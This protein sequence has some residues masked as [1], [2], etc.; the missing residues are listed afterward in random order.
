MTTKVILDE[1]INLDSFKSLLGKYQD[2]KSCYRELKINSITG[3]K[4][5]FEISELNPP[6]ICGFEKKENYSYNVFHVSQSCFTINS[7]DMVV[8][9]KLQVIDIHLKIKILDTESG[10]LLSEVLEDVEFR[11]WNTYKDGEVYEV[12]GF[13][14]ISSLKLSA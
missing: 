2:F 3:K 10:K 9:D 4:S 5:K 12:Y 6:M 1:F 14:A 7:I 8:N 13:Y 11:T